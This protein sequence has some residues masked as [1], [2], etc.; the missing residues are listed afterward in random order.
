MVSESGVYDSRP[1]A[2]GPRQGVGADPFR[3]SSSATIFK[4]NPH[5]MPRGDVLG[6][7]VG[8]EDLLAEMVAHVRAQRGKPRPRH[9]FLYGP[10]GIGKTTMLLVLRY[11]IADNPGL[12]AAFD[13]VQFSE[14]ERRVANLPSFA[15]RTLELLTKARREAKAEGA[16]ETEADLKRAQSAPEQAFDILLAAGARTPDRQ[17]LLLM[18]N[19]DEL[20]IAATSGRSRRFKSAQAEP[21]RQMARLLTSPHFVVVATALQSPKKRKDFPNALLEHF[22]RIAPLSPLDNAMGFL[23]KRAERDRRE[24]FLERLPGLA[25]RIEGL[26]RLADG[27]PRLLVFLYDCLGDRPL[28][29]LVE[30]VQRT[31]DDLTPMYQDV[32][33][34]LLNR[35][36]A[37]ALE[38]LAA[39]GGVGRAREIADLTFQDEQTV[40]TFLGDLCDLGLAVR[41]NN[42]HLPGRD[43]AVRDMVFR[44]H[45]PLFQIW[46]E[47]RHL[48][49][50]DSM[51]LVRFFSLLT[52]REE[53]HRTLG[54]V[55]GAE[56]AAVQPG[57]VNLMEEVTEILDPGWEELKK[58]YVDDI[59]T[60]GGTLRDALAALDQAVEQA[61]T[62]QAHR[63]VG[64]CAVRS[65]VKYDLGDR[66][67]AEADLKAADAHLREIADAET[68]VKFLTAWSGFLNSAGDYRAAVKRAEEAAELSADL[69]SASARDIH[70]SSLMAL[71]SAHHS[72]SDY[73]LALQIA[74]QAAGQL[75]AQRTPGLKARV[76]NLIGNIHDSLGNYRRAEEY[77]KS[78]LAIRREKADRGGEAAS[79][80]NLGIVYQSLGDYERARDYHEKSLAI[81]QE[82]GNRGGEATSLDS[83]GSV[84]RSLGDYERARDYHEKSLTIRQEIGNRSGEAISLNNL[85]NV[86]QSLGDYKRA[87]DSFGKAYE[88]FT[89][90]GEHP[91]V[92]KSAGNIISSLFHLSASAVRGADASRAESLFAQALTLAGDAGAE[93]SLS[94]FTNELVIPALQHSREVSVHLLSFVEQMGKHEA[95]AG[96]EEE[97]V[98]PT[99][100]ALEALLGFYASGGSR[101]ALND[102]GPTEIF[103]VRSLTDRIERPEHVRARELLRD[104][105]ADDAKDA[106][107][108]I[109]EQ[110]PED[111]EALL[112]LAKMLAAQGELDEAEG[113]LH[114]VLA[115][116]KDFAP[117]LLV[118]AQIELRRGRD[119]HAVEILQG[120]LNREPPFHEAFPVLAQTLRGQGRFDD[121]AETLGKWREAVEDPEER[122]R[123]GVWIPEAYVLAGDVARARSAMP[124][125]DVAPEDTSARLLLELLRVFLALEKKDAEEARR[126]AARLLELAADMPPGQAPDILSAEFAAQAKERLAEREYAFFA[127]IPLAVARR[128]D[129]MKFAGEFLSEDEVKGLSARVAEEGA[130]ALDA[131]RSG[132]IQ[133]FSDL[134]RTSS[135]SIGP[136]AAISALGDAYATLSPAHRAVLLDVFTGAI[137]HG[138]PAE[139]DAALGAIGKH[140]PDLEPLRRAQCL[141]AILD[142]A[143]QAG[144]EALSRE[145]AAQVLNI[146]YPNLTE[147]ERLDVR[148]G[149]EA[150]REERESPAMTEF[151]NETV[152]QVDREG[153]R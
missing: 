122:Q 32:I 120:L 104:G 41:P 58:A 92:R 131:L 79:L 72:L 2:P 86:Y 115:R 7:F 91:N 118:L 6:T 145:R 40:R 134:A 96:E 144:K 100:K 39:R 65:G 147:T 98:R 77:H 37:A 106:F 151:F 126:Y 153:K 29:D 27:N 54:E 17:A 48:G 108:N 84:Y 111:V 56:G 78:A 135:R 10:R 99:L 5:Q 150:V 132:R 3:V 16:E 13:V 63:R 68:R 47:M 138:A 142:L 69:P 90:L 103:L 143:A 89:L 71:A 94:L 67:G 93:R 28:P 80:G 34:R 62:E 130:L 14:E 66:G 44:T 74:E 139:V 119:E 55:R 133:G 82:T 146:L 107:E 4:Y 21:V 60:E 124:G 148:R 59:L 152:P 101:K 64:L 121:L 109:L 50:E 42:L 45:P 116:E 112:N 117:A 125:E 1:A 70:A 20:V 76:A 31:V 149:L 49:C 73:R 46:Y 23:R 128:V 38:M 141:T 61:T 75:D 81:E 52:E 8:R 95:F 140:F 33:D 88:L 22:E 87:L 83:L 12:R 53:A 102:L 105:K 136:V 35:G 123:L 43:E 85:G 36:Q 127:E 137:R 11:R 18:D 30:I 114:A 97:A 9:L 19:F 15:I 113:K 51:Y 24:G 110:S 26:N 25:P 57:M 129:P